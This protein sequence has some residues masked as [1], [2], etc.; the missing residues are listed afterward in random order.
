[1]KSLTLLSLLAFKLYLT[2]VAASPSTSPSL[3]GLELVARQNDGPSGDGMCDP[4]DEQCSIFNKRDDVDDVIVPRMLGSNETHFPWEEG[5]SVRWI[6]Q[7]E[8]YFYELG[9][10]AAD[11]VNVGLQFNCGTMREVCNNICYGIFCKRAPATLTINRLNCRDARKSNNCGK[12]NPN[13]CSVRWP[14]S[15]G[16][17]FA[18]GYSCDEYPFASTDEGLTYS[19]RT[20]TRCVP[21]GQNSS[22]GGQIS[23]FYRTGGKLKQRLPHGT[24]FN[25]LLDKTRVVRDGY[26]E[27]YPNGPAPGSAICN[28][29]RGADA[30][31]AA[32]QR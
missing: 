18:P 23:R 3:L 2:W 26:C 25:V 14:T 4:C 7:A 29:R 30:N 17:P 28:S 1:M 5:E 32:S 16:G 8:G 6:N 24:K 9:Q 13:Y 10:P 22:Q 27:G 11:F 15:K 21:K 20:A 19:D 31:S 12:F